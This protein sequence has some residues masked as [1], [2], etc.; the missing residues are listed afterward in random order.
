[1][2][3]R[4]IIHLTPSATAAVSAERLASI[5]AGEPSPILTL[6]AS[7][8]G[9]LRHIG[10]GRLSDFLRPS[11]G[12]RSAGA[13]GTSPSSRRPRR[14]RTDIHFGGGLRQRVRGRVHLIDERPQ[15]QSAADRG[16]A[17]GGDVNEVPAGGFSAAF[18]DVGSRPSRADLFFNSITKHD[19]LLKT[20]HVIAMRDIALQV[21]GPVRRA[22]ARH[23]PGKP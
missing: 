13:S 21:S 19:A 23:W 9:R 18:G 5:V 14:I 4:L 17:A 6:R 1:V 20:H 2:A 15:R 3:Q 16:G 8:S 10:F 12:A 7:R 22:D 11:G